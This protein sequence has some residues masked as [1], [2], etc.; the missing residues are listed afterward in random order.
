MFSPLQD[1]TRCKFGEVRRDSV[2]VLE[3]SN[4]HYLATRVEPVENRVEEEEESK[5]RVDLDRDS[6]VSCSSDEQD[7]LLSDSEG[8]CLDIS[9]MKS[10]DSGVYAGKM[11][12]ATKIIIRPEVL[13][14]PV[15]T[16][17]SSSINSSTDSEPTE[18][19]SFVADS[20]DSEKSPPKDVEKVPALRL[21]RRVSSVWSLLLEEDCSEPDSRRDC[22]TDSKQS[23]SISVS[24]DDVSVVRTSVDAQTDCEATEAESVDTKA[25]SEEDALTIVDTSVTEEDKVSA[26]NFLINFCKMRLFEERF[27]QIK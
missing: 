11:A 4:S 12:R 22:K 26:F 8:A 2:E 27:V 14:K 13:S 1:V 23:V 3:H 21:Q 20:E 10:V 19:I 9:E 25:D 6:G 16:D 24:S 5:G 18:R 7:Q 15:K 17:S